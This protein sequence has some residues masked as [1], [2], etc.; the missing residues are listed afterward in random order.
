M[1]NILYCLDENYN[2]QAFTSIVSLLDNVSEKIN[3]FIIHKNP[4]TFKNLPSEIQYHN[5]LNLLNIIKFNSKGKFFPNL[6]NTHV[7]EA[8]YYRIYISE[9]LPED[10]NSI[11]YL[12]CDII[13][14]DDPI[15][16]IKKVENELIN[17]GSVIAAKTEF[18]KKN[19]DDIFFNEIGHNLNLY[20]NAGVMFI[21]FDR[22]KEFNIIDKSQTIIQDKKNKLTY[23]DQDILN[24]IFQNKYIAIEEGLNLRIGSTLKEDKKIELKSSDVFIHYA[25]SNKPWTLEG[26]SHINS[27]HYQH[28]FKKIYPKSYHLVNKWR[29]NSLRILIKNTLNF[30]LLINTKYLQLLKSYILT[31]KK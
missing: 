7:S 18:V 9:F 10:I 11:L 19:E 15:E 14:V 1:H 26:V 29:L 3:I 21:N 13:C 6:E 22:W 5:K 28:N 20:F 24:I 17:S 25:G 8:T 23:W 27:V 12:D 30:S 16:Q 4:D 2:K 31:L